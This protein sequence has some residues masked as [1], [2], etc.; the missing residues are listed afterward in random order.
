MSENKR[1]KHDYS[2]LLKYMR[3]LDDGYSFKYIHK[4]MASAIIDL[5]CYG[6]NISKKATQDYKSKRMSRLIML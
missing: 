6:K 2:A 1:K 5:K 3:L 4:N